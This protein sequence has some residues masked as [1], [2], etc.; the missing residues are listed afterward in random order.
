MSGQNEVKPHAKRTGWLKNNN[1]P[2]DLSRAR[3]C[4]A[5]TRHGSPCRAPA[6][7]NGR[8]R[9]HGGK[10][11]GPK[12]MEGIERIRAAHLTHGEYT[13]EAQAE[14]IYFRS[15]LKSLEGTVEEINNI[16]SGIDISIK[17]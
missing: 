14:K 10:S 15:L 17:K 6:M 7:R 4:N 5:R 3:R 1:P 11:T 13:K 2:G 12:T 9:M 16:V 8:C